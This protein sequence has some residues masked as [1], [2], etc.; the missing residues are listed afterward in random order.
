MRMI[1]HILGYPNDIDIKKMKVSRPRV[2]RP[3]KPRGLKAVCT[4]LYTN[5][6]HCTL[7]LVDDNSPSEL[8]SFLQSSLQY[9]PDARI[10]PTNALKHDLFKVDNI[11]KNETNI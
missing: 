6:I 9:S 11:L 2:S 8:L 1:I 3:S 7:Q 10:T 4:S 5:M